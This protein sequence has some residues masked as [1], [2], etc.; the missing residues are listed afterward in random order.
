MFCEVMRESVGN[1]RVKFMH[2]LPV[3]HDPNTTV[4]REKMGTPA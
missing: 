3:F 4:G 1:P 2:C